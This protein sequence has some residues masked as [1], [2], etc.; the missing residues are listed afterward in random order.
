MKLNKPGAQLTSL[1]QAAAGGTE[2]LHFLE[3]CCKCIRRCLEV[4]DYQS[5]EELSTQISEG[6]K[7]DEEH[8]AAIE[9]RINTRVGYLEKD[10]VIKQRQRFAALQERVE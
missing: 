8:Q 5:Y 9:D 4:G 6:V 7:V 3:F 10:Y 2:N 1:I